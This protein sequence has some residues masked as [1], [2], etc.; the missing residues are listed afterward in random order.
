MSAGGKGGRREARDPEEH[1][2]REVGRHKGAQ[3]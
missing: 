2:S 1:K 3:D